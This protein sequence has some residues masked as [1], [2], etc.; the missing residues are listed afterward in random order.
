MRRISLVLFLSLLFV[1]SPAFAQKKLDTSALDK[2]V[3]KILKLDQ[4]QKSRVGI[5][6]KDVDTGQVVYAH[7]EDE[8]FNPA[9]NM[10]LVTAAVALER[11]GPAFAFGTRLSAKNVANGVVKGP[12]YL[13]GEGD[14]LLLW[15]DLL[16]FASE[17][18]AQGITKIEDG[19]V[20]DDTEFAEGFIPPGYDQKDEDA[21]YRAPIGAVSLNFNSQ[22]VVI[23]PGDRK[24]DAATAYLLPPND[25]VKL[26][27][28]VRTRSG[29]TQRISASSVSD[30]DGTRIEVR[31][32]IGDRAEP[33]RVRKRIDNPSLFTGSALKKAL[34]LAGIEVSGEVR[35]GSRPD[36]TKTL[37]YHRSR[38][39]AYIVF[40]MNKWSNNFMAE[41]LY[42]FLGRGDG[43]AKTERS[44]EVVQ[45]YLEKAGVDTAGFKTFN[46]SG[47]YDGNAITPRQI[48]DLLDFMHD[49]PVYP[50]YAS[51]LAVAGRDGTL[52]NRLKSAKTRGTLRG[53]TGTLNNV[54]ALSGYMTTKSG[55][56]VAYSILIND[57]PVRAWR[58]RR[59]QDDIAEALASFDK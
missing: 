30:G 25:N 59:V 46:G 24:G 16:A 23:R 53:K 32:V 5:Y 14:P 17:L 33:V 7:N 43:P 52:S 8:P 13:K 11:V 15:E 26:V 28:K 47:L 39:L 45:S 22:T 35:R 10:K 1:G 3:G 40:L 48:V 38:S 51:A 4:L 19:I 29:R 34:E 41:M 44:R 57:P 55:R 50:E 12:L 49:R 21:S 54:T 58:L 56:H 36:G 9:S 27:N 37:H 31:G 2:E 42:R 20:V 6:A 18:K